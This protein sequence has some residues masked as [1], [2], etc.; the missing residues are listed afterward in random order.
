LEGE[1]APLEGD[2]ADAIDP[3]RFLLR[4]VRRSKL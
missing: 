4:R 1:P 2:L 3:A